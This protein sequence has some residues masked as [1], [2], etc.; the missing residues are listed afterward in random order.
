MMTR[1]EVTAMK[2][3]SPTGPTGGTGGIGSIVGAIEVIRRFQTP[4]NN[5]REF[6][7]CFEF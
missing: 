1:H 3:T 4:C 6:F 7:V 2:M 5:K